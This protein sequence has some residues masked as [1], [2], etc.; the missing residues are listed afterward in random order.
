MLDIGQDIGGYFRRTREFSS[1]IDAYISIISLLNLERKNFDVALDRGCRKLAT[2][3]PF[4]TEY[5]VFRIGNG[6]PFGNLAYE[7]F[8][9]FSHCYDGRCCPPAFLIGDDLGIATL[10]NSH[11]GVGGPEIDSDYLTHF[12]LLLALY[13]HDSFSWSEFS[14]SAPSPGF[15]ADLETTTM[16]G[17]SNRSWIVYPF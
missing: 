4:D 3:Q 12:S 16:A 15:P 8:T 13:S 14:V 2:N 10:H 1:Q 6:L 5:R 17:R 11:T 7:S 9:I